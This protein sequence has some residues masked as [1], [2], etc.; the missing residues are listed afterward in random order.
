M[1]FICHFS[2]KLWTF[3]CPSKETKYVVKAFKEV[4]RH[5]GIKPLILQADNGGEFIGQQLKEYC[6]QVTNYF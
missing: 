2:K 6:E 5:A 1:N 4:I 3:S